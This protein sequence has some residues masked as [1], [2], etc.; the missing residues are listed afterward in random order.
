MTQ[1]KTFHNYTVN[2]GKCKGLFKL[3]WDF[4]PSE[5]NYTIPA[6]VEFKWGD[7]TV[8]SYFRGSDEYN[9]ELTNVGFLPVYDD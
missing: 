9:T 8:D 7:T 2:L 5:Y 3:H 4:N 1:F 6:R